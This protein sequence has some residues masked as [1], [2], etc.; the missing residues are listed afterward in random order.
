MILIS[1][2]QHYFNLSTLEF[3]MTPAH[4][5]LLTHSVSKSKYLHVAD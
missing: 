1:N 4:D 5:P 2:R 3:R